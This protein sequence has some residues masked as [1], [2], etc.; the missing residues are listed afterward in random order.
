MQS[1]LCLLSLPFYLIHLEDEGN[2]GVLCRSDCLFHP[3]TCL[4]L[5]PR[6]QKHG[7]NRLSVLS[8]TTPSLQH[9]CPANEV[10][11]CDSLLHSSARAVQEHGQ[12]RQQ[13]ECICRNVLQKSPTARKDPSDLV[14]RTHLE[15]PSRCF[16]IFNFLVFSLWKS[17][18]SICSKYKIILHEVVRRKGFWFD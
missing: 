3:I 15:I 11:V 4:Q 18:C 1:C 8:K 16:S 17:S 5:F 13:F 10:T 12:D 14:S 9:W 2:L 7:R 6:L